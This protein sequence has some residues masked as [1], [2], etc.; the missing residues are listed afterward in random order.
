MAYAPVMNNTKWEEVRT[1]MYGLEDLKPAWRTRDLETGYVSVWDREWFY[2]L[3]EG[4]YDRIEW[5]EIRV[6][7]REQDAAVLAALTSIHVPGE[8][9]EGGYRVYGHV[10]L[11][12][13]VGYLNAA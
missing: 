12:K 2:H 10:P 11:G 5:L 7:S 4:G 3:S 1:A 8:R 6:T 9:I 13:P